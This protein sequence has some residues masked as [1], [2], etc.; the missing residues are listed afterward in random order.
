MSVE[1]KLVSDA[2]FGGEGPNGV[3]YAGIP[4]IFEKAGYD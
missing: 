4:R 2:V 3:A 1:D